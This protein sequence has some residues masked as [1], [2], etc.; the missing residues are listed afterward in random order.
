MKELKQTVWPDYYHYSIEEEGLRIRQKAE[1]EF[2]EMLIDFEDIGSREVILRLKPSPYAIL[3][4]LSV[5]FNVMFI[6]V[7]VITEYIPEDSIYIGSI[8]I[9][10]V[11]PFSLWGAQLFKFS[12]KKIIKGDSRN[13]P[14]FY[15]AKQ[16]VEVDAFIASLHR[17]KSEYLREQYSRI[18]EYSDYFTLRSRFIWLKTNKIIDESELNELLEKIESR[19]VVDGY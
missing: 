15:K 4:F 6:L 17:S 3:A 1:N 9:A 19:K 8:L 7:F 5:L 12:K 18:D 10:A 13:I 2:V 16:Q 11:V 14:F